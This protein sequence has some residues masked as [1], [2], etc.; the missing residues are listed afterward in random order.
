MSD[1]NSMAAHESWSTEAGSG[2]L[3][4]SGIG[5]V[6]S[7]RFDVLATRFATYADKD[8]T[9]RQSAGSIVPVIGHG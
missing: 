5:A 8:R 4:W 9:P 7:L 2:P 3:P 1:L 6:W